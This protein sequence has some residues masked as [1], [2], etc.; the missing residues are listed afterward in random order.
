MKWSELRADE[1]ASDNATA[2]KARIF[3]LLALAI[4][5][6]SLAGAAVL[7]SEKF[8][9]LSTDASYHWSGISCLLGTLFIILSAFL[10]RA[11]TLPPADAY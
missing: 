9:S 6:A 10:M 4:A 7:M 11:G 8:L 2:A 3:L 1:L 5:L